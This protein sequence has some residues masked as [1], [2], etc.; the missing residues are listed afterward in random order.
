MDREVMWSS[1]RTNTEVETAARSTVTDR[2]SPFMS[3]TFGIARQLLP[4]PFRSWVKA[5]VHRGDSCVCPLCGYRGDDWDWAGY[6][7]PVLRDK[8]VVGGGR[9]RS[10]CYGCGSSD[11]ERLIYIYLR[12]R[13]RL[14]ADCTKHV[15]HIAPEQR[16]SPKLQEAGFARYVRGDLAGDGHRI[17]PM[18]VTALPFPNDAFDVVIC[19]HVLEHVPDDRLAMR[20]LLRVLRPGGIALLQVPIST[21]SATTDEEP[22]LRDPAERERRFGQFDHVRIYGQDYPAR[23]TATGFSVTRCRLAPQYPEY[24]LHPDEELFVCAS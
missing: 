15:L 1:R 8:R 12:D 2:R 20:E 22:E 4:V 17:Q 16:L 18:D 11:R 24:G 6:D 9:R 21:I 7:H 19:N 14:F 13:L 3:L 10:A 5:A 23:L